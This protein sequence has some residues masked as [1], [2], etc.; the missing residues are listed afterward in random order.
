MIAE[1]NGFVAVSSQP[2]CGTDLP[3]TTTVQG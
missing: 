2:W 1:K 3:G